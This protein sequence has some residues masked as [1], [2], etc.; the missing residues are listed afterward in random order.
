MKKIISVTI[1]CMV[2]YLIFGFA[3]ANFSALTWHW[4]LRLLYLIVVMTVF[5]KVGNNVDEE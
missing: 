2:W 4:S 5:S 3:L 1:A